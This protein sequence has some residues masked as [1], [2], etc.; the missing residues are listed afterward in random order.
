MND[1]PLQ[2]KS[3]VLQALGVIIALIGLIILVL[4]QEW[5]SREAAWK[6][7]CR[8]NLRQIALAMANYNDTYHCYPP[9]YVADGAGRPMH[10]WRVLLLP[11]LEFPEIYKD[12]RFD[13]PWDGPHNRLLPNFVSQIYQC[14][15][16]K[17][18]SKDSAE[19]DY[20]VV[21]GPNT[22]FP[23]THSVSAVEISDDKADTILV[24]EV[25]RTGIHW[26][27]PRDMPLEQAIRGVNVKGGLSISSGHAGG[28][29]VTTADGSV[30]FLK[31][32]ATPGLLKSLLERND[33]KPPADPAFD[34]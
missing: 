16:D 32:E 15:A 17:N 13:E 19:T 18:R 24:V 3:A 12:Y 1:R 28:A 14:P 31:D 11:F 22:V 23:S 21:V 34:R 2:H 30:D 7:Q 33:G 25:S 20:V 27:E 26:M 4:S 6:V 9:A 29:Q 8:N 5:G 10:S